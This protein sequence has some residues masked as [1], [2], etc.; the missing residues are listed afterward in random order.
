MTSKRAAAA[1]PTKV[2]VVLTAA[3][4]TKRAE[5]ATR[6]VGAKPPKAAAAPLEAALQSLQAAGHRTLQQHAYQQIREALMTGRFAPGQKLTIRGLAEALDLSPT[7]IREAV[8]RL[9]TE[10]ALRL[11]S[12]RR[13]TVPQLSAAEFAELRDI[14]LALEGLATERA[15]PMLDDKQLRS[16]RRLDTAIHAQRRSGDVQRTMRSIQQFHHM[17]YAAAQLPT[18]KHLIENLWLRS[19][20]HLHLIFPDFAGRE[21]GQQRARTLAAIE[22]RDAPGAREA[23]LADLRQTADFLI[24]V[25]AQR[26]APGAP[27]AAPAAS[28]AKGLTPRLRPTAGSRR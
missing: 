26:E 4:A 2:A 3:K 8:H 22:Q 12:T 11:G 10:G 25:L 6:T 20:P 21:Q 14:R 18:L 28:R 16:L 5:A 27:A 13:L 17:L 1:R 23:M 9:T 19:G 15:V 7:P 24:G